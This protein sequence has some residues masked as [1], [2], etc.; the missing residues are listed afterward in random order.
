MDSLNF[1]K[2]QYG[3]VARILQTVEFTDVFYN[4]DSRSLLMK[5]YYELNEFEALFTFSDTFSNYLRRNKHIS[6][7]QKTVY[8]N[9]VKFIT[10]LARVKNRDGAISVKLKT[11]IETS[12]EVADATW[13]KSKV[14]EL[15]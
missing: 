14:E 4:L 10:R 13:L 3:K 7:Y 6:A 15:V 12:R 8:L 5:T 2:Q 9:L 11:E 1:Y